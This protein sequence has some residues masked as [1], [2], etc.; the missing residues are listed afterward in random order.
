VFNSFLFLFFIFYFLFFIFYFFILRKNGFEEYYSTLLLFYFISF[1][2][3]EL[4]CL[5]ERTGRSRFPEWY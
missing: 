5:L 1:L 3:F 4:T 2:I